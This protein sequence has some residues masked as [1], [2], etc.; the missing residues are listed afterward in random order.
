MQTL[1]D[2]LEEKVQVV[3]EQIDDVTA[4]DIYALWLMAALHEDDSR[5]PELNAFGYSTETYSTPDLIDSYGSRWSPNCIA[6]YVPH[7]LCQPEMPQWKQAGDAVG[8]ALRDQLFDAQNTR[9]D[10][11]DEEDE[12]LSRHAKLQHRENLGVLELSEAAELEELTILFDPNGQWSQQIRRDADFFIQ[13]RNSSTQVVFAEA[14]G[15]VAR[16]LH[17]K[18][19]VE[20]VCGRPVPIGISFTNDVDERFLAAVVREANPVD[21][22]RGIEEELLGATYEQIEAR[23]LLDDEI[24]KLTE[25]DQAAFWVQA[26]YET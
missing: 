20:R 3:F 26:L 12:M 24:A 1:T 4:R 18:G 2:Y 23:Y 19:V 14:L 15:E 8:V 9:F 25:E 5:Y 7:N 16:R 13:Q 10:R 22:S 6:A 21:L 17:Q 11:T